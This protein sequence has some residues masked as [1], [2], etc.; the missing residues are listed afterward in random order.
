MAGNTVNLVTVEQIQDH[1]DALEEQ[2][3]ANITTGQAV[4]T[5]WQTKK[6]EVDS[7]LAD[8][9][10]TGLD[11]QA[12]GAEALQRAGVDKT[13]DTDAQREADAQPDGTR[14]YTIESRTN[15]T[16]T[17]GAWVLVGQ[18]VAP[19]SADLARRN[20]KLDDLR[21]KGLLDGPQQLDG[22]RWL[23]VPKSSTTQTANDIT[24]V[25]GTDCLWFREHLGVYATQWALPLTG[26]KYTNETAQLVINAANE[27][28]VGSVYL[29]PGVCDVSKI[30]FPDPANYQIQS[31]FRP[32]DGL[33][34][35]GAGEATVLR[36]SDNFLSGSDDLQSNAHFF[37]RNDP[38]HD[39]HMRDFVVDGNGAKNL[40][41]PHSGQSGIRN[42]IV[43]RAG[44]G[45]GNCTWQR[46]K[47]KNIAGANGWSLNG[48]GVGAKITHCTTENGGPWVGV[49]NPNNHDFSAGYSTWAD[50]RIEASSFITDPAKHWSGGFELHGPYSGVHNCFFEGM[51]PAVYL[52]NELL[53]GA[54]GQYVTDCVMKKVF[55]GINIT[56]Y[57][58]LGMS[59]L[60]IRGNVIELYKSPDDTSA[61]VPVG[62]MSPVGASAYDGVYSGPLGNGQG[63]TD[64]KIVG[65]TVYAHES[66]RTTVAAQ[67]MRLNGL[68][69]SVVT[70]NTLRDLGGPGLWYEGS[71]W[72]SSVVT[73][74]NNNFIDCCQ[75]PTQNLI[76]RGGMV[77]AIYGDADRSTTPNRLF[78]FRNVK[79]GANRY[80]NRVD[81]EV[82]ADGT[83]EKWES[84]GRM[85]AAITVYG[86][87]GTDRQISQLTIEPQEVENVYRR[88]FYPYD[89]SKSTNLNSVNPEIHD[90]P[91]VWNS[92]N[93]PIQGVI[94]EPGDLVI[95]G[96]GTLARYALDMPPTYQGQ[97]SGVTAQLNAG[98]TIA[99]LSGAERIKLR[100]SVRIEIAGAGAGGATLYT[101]ITRIVG[102]NA[103]EVEDAAVTA[104]TGGALTL[105]SIPP[106]T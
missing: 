94:L 1:L 89:E 30:L 100:P 41:P 97:V 105:T 27:D 36:L 42:Q 21:G 69:D 18:A 64:A 23:P 5:E 44:A 106:T 55:Q 14:S 78:S 86:T 93:K 6:G 54:E 2:R 7:G 59:G 98:S 82:R 72:G 92:V 84:K 33:T 62:I 39:I 85:Y 87:L 79:I 70:G 26:G 90:S 88:V 22:S 61:D 24:R 75:R 53:A 101:V 31:F 57:S 46:V 58:N 40:N 10:Q 51:R 95:Y 43:F 34:I 91:K 96:D 47:L 45:G 20:T 74:D 12:M 65:N 104:T 35:Y 37:N 67:G 9:A 52:C 29:S 28:G 50:T 76:H 103:I 80:V 15:H 68:R 8:I 49:D 48:A 32:P 66:Q 16:R 99:T 19:A 17:N 102:V 63:V 56:T 38:M 73:I 83:V 11:V 77:L 81:L 25:A 4:A 60:N 71:A 13:Y 3:Q